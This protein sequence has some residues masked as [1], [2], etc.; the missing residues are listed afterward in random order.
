MPLIKVVG[1]NSCSKLFFA[2]HVS[3]VKCCMNNSAKFF[4]NSSFTVEVSTT[5]NQEKWEDAD[6]RLLIT[7]YADD[8][9]TFVWRRSFGEATERGL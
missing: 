5:V 7:T 3:S 6:V 9:E 4:C 2:M 8:I 1:R